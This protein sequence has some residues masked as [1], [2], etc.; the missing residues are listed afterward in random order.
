M[1]RPVDRM[2][3][4]ALRRNPVIWVDFAGGNG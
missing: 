3:A 2:Q 1:A 4:S